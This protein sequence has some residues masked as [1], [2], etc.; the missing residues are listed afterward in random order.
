MRRQ[1]SSKSGTCTEGL[2][3]DGAGIS[4]K[5]G[6][7]Y[8]GRSVNLLYATG[9][10]RCRDGLAE[11]SRWHSRFTRPNRRPEHGLRDRDLNFDGKGETDK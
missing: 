6:A 10:E 11:V 5:V 9:A 8:P 2:H 1:I 7:H 3:V 4:G